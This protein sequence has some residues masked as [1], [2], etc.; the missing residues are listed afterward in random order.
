MVVNR[1]YVIGN[2]GRAWM[3]EGGVV[4]LWVNDCGDN[5]SRRESYYGEHNDRTPLYII[6]YLIATVVAPCV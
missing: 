5:Y 1:K 3:G 4:H 6:L 2:C